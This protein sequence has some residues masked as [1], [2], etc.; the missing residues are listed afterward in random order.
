MG[1]FFFLL[2]FLSFR[3]F[4]SR[5]QKHNSTPSTSSVFSRSS[6]SSSSSGTMSA[7]S[8]VLLSTCLPSL[9]LPLSLSLFRQKRARAFFVS[10]SRGGF[11][12]GLFWICIDKIPKTTTMMMW[13]QRGAFFFVFFS[14]SFLF[15]ERERVLFSC[16]TEKKTVERERRERETRRDCLISSFF[17][18]WITPSLSSPPVIAFFPAKGT[19]ITMK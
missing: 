7:S 16:G 6:S 18:F 4:L 10:S 1:R 13:T 15:F 17:F 2:H 3:G 11:G 9:F 5:A 12:G 19:K 8:G 14:F